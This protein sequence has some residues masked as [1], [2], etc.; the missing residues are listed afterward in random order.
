MPRKNRNTDPARTEGDEMSRNLIQFTE[1]DAENV[2]GRPITED[3]YRR[4]VKAL[5]FSSMPDAFVDVVSSV[6]EDDS[7]D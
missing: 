2:L 1:E 7:K 5:P 3:E 4:L 6:C